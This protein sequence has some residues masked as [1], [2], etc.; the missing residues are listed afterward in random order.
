MY[1]ADTRLK[2]AKTAAAE[3]ED[4]LAKLHSSMGPELFEYKRLTTQ[5]NLITA[6]YADSEIN[7]T[8]A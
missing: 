6:R 4:A 5:R 8:E 7:L 2:A 1:D 3:A